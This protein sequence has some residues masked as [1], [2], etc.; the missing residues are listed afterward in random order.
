MWIWERDDWPDF[1]Y[2]AKRF[3]KLER[4]FEFNRL[5]MLAGIV[6][7]DKED[8]RISKLKSRVWRH[9]KVPRLRG[10]NWTF[11]P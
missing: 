6:T 2:D 4:K 11:R 8:A 10:R 7:F 9:L 3:K 5:N 1:E